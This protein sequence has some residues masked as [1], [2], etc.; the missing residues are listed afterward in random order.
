MRSDQIPIRGLAWEYFI[1]DA[2]GDPITAYGDKGNAFMDFTHPDVQ[3]ILINQAVAVAK[4]G[5]YDG[6][7]LDW[8]TEDGVILADGVNAAWGNTEAS[9]FRGF[10]A[11]QDAR[12]NILAG[13]RSQVRDDFIIMVNSNRRQF[14]RTAWAIN[15]TFMETLRDHDD[16]YTYAGLQEIESTLRWAEATLREPRVNSVEGWGVATQAPDSDVN[17]RWMRAFTTLTLT[18]SDGYVLYNIGYTPATGGNDHQH[19]WYDFWDV[20]LGQ[21]IGAKAALYE[22]HEGLFIREFTNG[23]AVYNRS[24]QAQ[25]VSLA[26]KTYSLSDLD[27]DIYLKPPAWD[28]NSDGVVNVLDLVLVSNALGKDAPDVNPDVNGD[29]IVNILDLVAVA[30]RIG[31]Q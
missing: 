12:D 2:N 18:H 29:G 1:R 26:G 14:P 21:P 23:W 17:Q 28:V 8:W 3:R 27:G 24:G 25:T 20:P 11:E 5:L 9:G 19:L 10:Q 30:N 31:E 4:C 6:I 7:F 22:G 16:G 13:I 15:G